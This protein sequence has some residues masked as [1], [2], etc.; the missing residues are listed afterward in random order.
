MD[1]RFLAFSTA[2]LRKIAIPSC[3]P[4]RAESCG[5]LSGRL[6][7]FGGLAGMC[8]GTCT[9]ALWSRKENGGAQS[10]DPHKDC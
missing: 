8:R 7:A 1:A 5:Y 4:M 9:A 6:V 2:N 10:G 3:R